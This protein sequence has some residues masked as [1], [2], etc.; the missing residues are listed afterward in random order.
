MKFIFPQNYNLKSKIFGLIDCSTAIV[1]IIWYIFVF[2]LC[3]LIIKNLTIKIFLFIILSMPLL[4]FSIIGF[5]HENILYVMFYL[6]KYVQS[7]KIYLYK[8]IIK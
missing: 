4:L 8:K 1:N 6:I 2:C 5:N 3:N 7:P